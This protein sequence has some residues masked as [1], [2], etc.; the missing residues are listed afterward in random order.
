MASAF[1]H[2]DG[3]LAYTAQSSDVDVAAVEVVDSA[4]L[5]VTALGVGRAD[6]VV[7]ATVASATSTESAFAVAVAAP[8]VEDRVVL[9]TDGDSFLVDLSR[10]FPHMDSETTVKPQS[11]SPHVVAVRI[12]NQVLLLVP[13]E[14][15]GVTEI[16]VSARHG[17]GWQ[18]TR[19]LQAVVE[20]APRPLLRGWRTTLLRSHEAE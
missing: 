19:R 14:D 7:T 17:N 1:H 4:T 5:R 10:L 11:N 3:D 9:D 15:E 2:P 18:T 12:R 8:A 16:V 13:G 6:V 20:L